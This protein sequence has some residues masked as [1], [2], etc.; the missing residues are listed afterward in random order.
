[1]DLKKKIITIDAEST[2]YNSVLICNIKTR[3]Y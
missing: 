1:M 2:Y 3:D